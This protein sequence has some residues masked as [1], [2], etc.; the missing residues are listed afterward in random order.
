MPFIRKIEARAYARATEITDR[1]ADAIL[2]IFPEELRQNVI[3]TGES[4]E[5]Q[6]GDE[7]VIFTGVLE[8]TEDCGLT[9]D[10]IINNLQK[11]DRGTLRRSLDLRLNAKSVFFLRIDKQG[12]FL[13]RLRLA[14]NADVI[15]T[16]IYF[17]DNPK[18]KPEDAIHFIEQ[19]LLDTEA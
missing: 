14:D 4:V 13:E 2:N 7:I 1:V 6:S 8:S 15:R 3:T 12:A 5:G 17:K 18:C 19:R 16:R 11:S 9:F 10:Y